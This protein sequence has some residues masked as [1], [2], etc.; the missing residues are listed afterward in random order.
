MSLSAVGSRVEADRLFTKGIEGGTIRLFCVYSEIPV[1]LLQKLQESRKRFEN[2]QLELAELEKDFYR[3]TISQDD[4][5]ETSLLDTMKQHIWEF[6]F[7]SNIGVSSSLA[8][9]FFRQTYPH[10]TLIYLRSNYL[11]H[12]ID[13]LEQKY[14]T[15]PMLTRIVA[16]QV[17]DILKQDRIVRRKTLVLYQDDCEPTLR[18]LQKEIT[19]WP[20]IL[21]LAIRKDEMTLYEASFSRTGACKLV[22][23]SYS[24]FR[25]D[26]YDFI[27]T[28][29][30]R[31]RNTFSDR[32]PSLSNPE[33]KLRPVTLTAPQ[34][35]DKETIKV[36]T[37]SL[38]EKYWCSIIHSGN[39]YLDMKIVDA[40]SGSSYHFIA[41]DTKATII[42]IWYKTPI[43]LLKLAA[44]ISD[45]IGSETEG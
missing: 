14:G 39:P 11:L 4:K 12:L 37:N 3:L 41:S 9:R 20:T 32:A 22:R 7:V 5:S 38:S 33:I 16:K 40:H 43:S 29:A 36:L 15:R 44:D 27:T 24:L 25:E 19:I 31:Q 17:F 28:E 18:I 21:Q 6:F 1:D 8:F 10:V 13:L 26:V 35:M 2:I 30:L 34:E 23:G 42:P 45:I